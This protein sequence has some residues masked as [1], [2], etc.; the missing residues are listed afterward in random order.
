M[1]SGKKRGPLWVV[2][3]QSDGIGGIPR[4]QLKAA[5]MWTSGTGSGE[6]GSILAHGS[7]RVALSCRYNMGGCTS[8]IGFGEGVKMGWTSK[9]LF[10]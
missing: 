5:R 4:I 2:Q 10:P 8:R 7:G 1:I 3:A 9:N 6:D